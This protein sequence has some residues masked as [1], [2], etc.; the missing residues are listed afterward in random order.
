MVS[1]PKTNVNSY[2]LTPNAAYGPTECAVV[3]ATAYKS[4]LDHKLI[5]SEPGTIGTG[6]G[7]RLWI[8]HPRNHDKLMPVGTV[9]ELVIEGP[10]VARGYLNEEE[11]TRK[12]FITNPGWAT[13]ISA[14][15]GAFE[16]VRMYKTG[17]LVRYNSDGSVSYVGRKDTQIKLNGQRVELGEI[18][19]HV[20]QNLPDNVQ[21]AVELIAPS[22]RSS[23]K[24]LAVFFAVVQP[25]LSDE[26]QGAEPA[27][28]DAAMSDDLLLPLDD[29]LRDICKNAENGLAG[30]LPT[31]MIPSIFI[32]VKK[33]PWTSAGKLDRNRLRGSVQDLSREALGMYRLSSMANKKQPK[34][35]T[36]KKIHKAVCAVLNLPASSVSIDDSFVRLGG[37]SISSMRL[38][39]MAQAEQLKLSFID[40][41]KSPKL[42]DLAKIASHTGPTS[43]L[44]KAIQPFELL[45]ESVKTSDVIAQASQQCQV[46][47]ENV[48]DVYPTSPLQDALVTLTIKQPGA[49]VAQHVLALPQSVDMP[50]FRSAW[51]KAVQEIDILR[52]R[53]IQL[54]SGA[55]MQAVIKEDPI[56]WKEATSLQDAQAEVSRIPSHLGGR[57]AAYTIVITASNKRYLVWTLHHA[58]YDGWS[59]Y[60]M[61]QRVQQIYMKGVSNIPQ[62]PYAQ[63]IKYL[64][65]TDDSVSKRFWK[66]SLS[67][68]DA[69]QFPRSSQVSSKDKPNGQTL[70]HLMK[71]APHKH[72]DVTPS[73]VIRAAWAI[74]LAAYTNSDDVVFGETL[75]GRDVA[76][77][78]IMDACG[79]VLT[80]VPTRVKISSGATVR[81]LLQ[82]IASN[83]TERIPHQHYGISA[84]KAIG[85]DVAAACDFQ[86]LLVV[87]TDNEALNDSMWSPHDNGN[88]G[89]FFTYPLVIECKIGA[90]STE[91]LLHFDADVI[92]PWHVHRLAYQFE[93]VLNQLQ[94]AT[95]LSQVSVFSDQDKQ[96]VGKWNA[97][98]PDVVDE[99]I[100]AVFYRNATAQPDAVAVAAFDGQLTYAELARYATS[101]AQDLL[102]LGAGPETLILI[103]LDKSLWTIVAMM[104][105]I[106]AGAA[107]VPLSPEHPASRHQQIIDT[108]KSSIMLCSPS[109]TSRF[110]ALV[111]HV[112]SV[113]G[114]A[115]RRLPACEAPLPQ[116]VKS[117]NAC[118]V[119]FTSGSTGVPK[120]A[121]LEHRNITS[122]AI[123]IGESIHMA[124]TSRVIQFGS[125]VFDASV[126]EIFI[127]LLLGA[128]VCVP[129]DEQRTTDLALALTLLKADWAFMTPS[130]ASTLDGPHSVPTL[131]TLAVGGEGMTTEVINKWASG[132]KLINGY[133]PTEC[134]IFAVANDKVREQ[135]SLTNIGNVLKTGRVWLTNPNNP[136]QLAPVGATAELCLEGSNVGRE[137]LN[138]PKRS[139]ETYIENPAFLKDFS[140]PAGNRIYRTGDLVSY[141]PDG[142][143]Q[144]IGRKDNQ[145]KLAGQRME[146]GEVEHNLQKDE[147]IRQVVVQL[148]K[149]GPCAKKLTAVVSFS[150]STA[151]HADTEWNSPLFD[152]ES[153]S[154]LNRSRE[155]LM[156]RV[157]PYMVPIVWIAVPRV[158]SL[159]STKFDKKQVGSW[160][161]RLD[162]SM[163]QKIMQ[164]E[165]VG[166]AGEAMSDAVAILREIWAKALNVPI[167]R[168]KPNRSW[169]CK[170]LEFELILFM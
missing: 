58:L 85:N 130:V 158:P 160:L 110:E 31:Y 4:T 35:D 123:A 112:R 162:D 49:Y 64:S 159:V 16:T 145:I 42:S 95:L 97:R 2:S 61:L 99:T 94:S 82:T 72:V 66:E 70:Q 7:C 8:V 102:N 71:L 143:I 117:N 14:R 10:T 76:V 83:V 126:L 60:L 135:R 166:D 41:F 141:D 124:P 67:G 104:G 164:T 119:L 37:D 77:T 154:L 111:K 165:A 133:G 30:S 62:T 100:P 151:A 20:G 153:L 43:Q 5:P 96:L 128:T 139:A 116:K 132:V 125:L 34:T 78:G 84:I 56:D 19:Y 87:Q 90:S 157:P 12:A 114:E 73:N 33:M 118:Y 146:L 109:Y 59:I 131:K 1:A 44:E 53:I 21:S 65:N 54:P 152:P 45:R 75:A 156:E 68:T 155:R 107:Y 29:Q 170:C 9:G 74:V 47:D 22:N 3:A 24:A 13:A 55:F 28:T 88:Q 101:L 26:E 121:V 32:P 168:V 38:I 15:N 17:D 40:I 167:E 46:S 79:P 129:S 147:S 105:I 148:P 91:V 6:S 23:A 36:E 11:K 122:N 93:S 81:E 52:T 169:L 50:K 115:I 51:E 18:E 144:Y 136:H 80:T 92:S 108:C 48:Q 142:S 57:L 106:L 161:D 127:P 138:D 150:A 39:A 134:C 69:Y 113:T 120:G 98:E 86:N 25:S 137:Y 103:C 140:T 63:F 149:A 27:I 89:N 163:Y